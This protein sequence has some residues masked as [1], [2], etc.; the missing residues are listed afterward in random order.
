MTDQS[1][2]HDGADRDAFIAAGKQKRSSNTGEMLHM[3]RSTR[4]WWMLPLVLILVVL[5][6]VLLITSTA[7]GPLIYTI[8]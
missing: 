4:K 6:L 8:F 7:A 2:D 1:P 5:G 3:V